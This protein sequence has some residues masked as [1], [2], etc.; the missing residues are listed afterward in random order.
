MRKFSV[1]FAAALVSAPVAVCAG[2]LAGQEVRIGGRGS[3]DDAVR[4]FGVEM[5]QAVD[6]A[7]DERNA[8]GGLLGGRVWPR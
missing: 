5:R 8:A 6:L 1:L 3:A 2:D 7:I 4:D